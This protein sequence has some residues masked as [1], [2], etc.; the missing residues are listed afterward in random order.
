MAAALEVL[1]AD[2]GFLTRAYELVADGRRVMRWVYAYGYFLD[3]ERDA[4]KRGLFDHLQGDANRSLE[5]LHGCAEGERKE[6]CA[7]AMGASPAEI[8][9]RYRSYKKKLENLTE[10]TRRYFENLVKAFETDLAEVKPAK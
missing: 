10:V 4:A 1:A 5:R 2:L 3:P 9:R 7:T 8:A 6:L